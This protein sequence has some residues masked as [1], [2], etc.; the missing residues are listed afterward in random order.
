[1]FRVKRIADGSI[2]QFKTCL[3]SKG[4]HQYLGVNYRETFSLVVKPIIVRDVL[5][6]EVMNEWE[7]CQ[8]DINNVFLNGALTEITSMMQP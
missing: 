3:V 2:D 7:L 6:I 8:L 4:F 1:M 5:T